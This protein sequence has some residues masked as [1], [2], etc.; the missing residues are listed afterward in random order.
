[1]NNSLALSQSRVIMPLPN[2]EAVSNENTL[3][4]DSRTRSR[5]STANSSLSSGTLPSFVSDEDD[6]EMLDR[7][8]P[9][10]VSTDDESDN[11]DSEYDLVDESVNEQPI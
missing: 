1:M 11:D 8:D 7:H 10:F 4:N 3:V 2:R 6:F 5:T 9:G